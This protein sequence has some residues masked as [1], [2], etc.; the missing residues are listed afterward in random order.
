MRRW[1]TVVALCLGGAVGLARADFA[2]I[3]VNVGGVPGSGS[4]TSDTGERVVRER[5]TAEMT[6]AA[7]GVRPG[8]P[9]L[10]TVGEGDTA[11]ELD[12]DPDEIPLFVAA[13]IEV[14]K[15]SHTKTFVSVKNGQQYAVKFPLIEHQWGK[16]AL[17]HGPEAYYVI[18][19]KLK[20]VAVQYKTRHDALQ[21]DKSN[22]E[23]LAS[24][25]VA[26]AEWALAHGLIKE[27]SSLMDELAKLNPTDQRATK[28]LKTYREIQTALDKKVTKG[29]DSVH[30]RQQLGCKLTVSDHYALLYDT[31]QTEPADV[32]RRRDRL[33]HSMRGFYYWFALHGKVLPVPDRRM[34]AVLFDFP[35]EF[36][37]RQAA[38]D[39]VSVTADSFFVQRDGLTVYSAKPIDESYDALNKMLRPLWQSGW[40]QDELLKG[41]GWNANRDPGEVAKNETMALVLRGIQEDAIVSSISHQNIRQLMAAAGLLPRN[42]NA[43]EWV[44]FGMASFFETPRAAPWEGF[45]VPSWIYLREYKDREIRKKADTPE[46]ALEWTVTDRYFRHV[47]QAKNKQAGLLRARAMSW[48]LTY[49]LANNHLDGLLRYHQEMAGMP[50]DMEF[51]DQTLLA[52]FLRAFDLGDAAGKIDRVKFQNF[53]KAWHQW[54]SVQSTEIPLNVRDKVTQLIEQ[55]KKT[56]DPSIGFPINQQEDTGG[57]GGGSGS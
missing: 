9:S 26:L 46:A 24:K 13:L 12:D 20:S 25:T 48:A 21:R 43:P 53:A 6:A 42:V 49:Y 56:G 37:R 41:G 32:I 16:T 47:D 55:R 3:I 22:S 57:F 10:P 4:G 19:T 11:E 50:R 7:P 8:L 39:A 15:T 38:F 17:Y 14:N 1:L 28:V 34:V 44:R 23:T 30:W 40:K 33:E 31:Q 54:I 52:C 35:D 51:D 18:D 29:D 5:P 36:K 2:L 27:F 45:G